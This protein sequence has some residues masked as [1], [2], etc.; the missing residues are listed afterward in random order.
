MLSFLFGQK[1][2]G[3]IYMPAEKSKSGLFI[4]S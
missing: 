4:E 2:Q 3:S 1:K